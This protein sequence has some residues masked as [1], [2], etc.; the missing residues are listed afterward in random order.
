MEICSGIRQSAFGNYSWIPPEPEE[1]VIEP[2]LDD[3]FPRYDN[4]PVFAQN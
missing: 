2:W 3:L 4:E 1:P